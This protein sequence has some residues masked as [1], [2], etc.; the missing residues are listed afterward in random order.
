MS[1]IHPTATIIVKDLPENCNELYIRQ[2]FGQFGLIIKVK[3]YQ[4][5]KKFAFIEYLFP[6]NAANAALQMSNILPSV[7]LV[8]KKDEFSGKSAYCYLTCGDCK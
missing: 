7:G 2:L 5:A 4:K 3:L 6:E 8:M 1:A